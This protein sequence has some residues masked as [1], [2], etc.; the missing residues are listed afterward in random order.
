MSKS[1]QTILIVAV[2]V[3]ILFL[4]NYFVTVPSIDSYTEGTLKVAELDAELDQLEKDIAQGAE[5]EAAIK[6]IDNNIA[7][8]GLDQYYDE[9]Y[10][11]HNFYVD[12]AENFGLTV[13]SLSLSDA[14]VVEAS[15][16]DGGSTI[17]S[18]HPLVSGQMEESEITTVP[19]HYEIITQTTSMTVNGTIDSILDYSDALAKNDIYM[20]VPAMSLSDFIDN[21]EAVDMALQF[22]K[23]SYQVAPAELT[24]DI[25]L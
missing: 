12:S 19:N 11:V 9:N 4:L 24:T 8:I 20:V 5:L 17:I 25:T 15:L 18:E 14:S 22:V 21:T 6:E 1:D 23:Y 10:S 7:T 16:A 13:N 2:T 3:L